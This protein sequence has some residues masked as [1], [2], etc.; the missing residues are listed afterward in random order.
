MN[1]LTDK[2][3]LIIDEV[4]TPSLYLKKIKKIG[5]ITYQDYYAYYLYYYV[6]MPYGTYGNTAHI[7]NLMFS[8][9]FTISGNRVTPISSIISVFY[10]AGIG[11]NPNYANSYKLNIT[12]DE[13][14]MN[15]NDIFVSS[16]LEFIN[17]IGSFISDY[18]LKNNSTINNNYHS[19]YYSVRDG[20]PYTLT[21]ALNR[22]IHSLMGD[23]RLYLLHKFL[24]K[25]YKF[26][27]TV[28]VSEQ[29]KYIDESRN[30]LNIIEAQQLLTSDLDLLTLKAIHSLR[31]KR[32][33]IIIDFDNP[34]NTHFN[35]YS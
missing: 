5:D 25:S 2:L 12:F 10:F 22:H 29:K 33:L 31:K 18:I 13:I 26:H 6:T 9:N 32:Y 1:K 21:S 15:M 30:Y 27:E 24:N 34:L 19:R 28:P 8:N 3:Q 20:L 7:Y 4:N 16:M 35:R 17:N 11:I 23:D 14:Y